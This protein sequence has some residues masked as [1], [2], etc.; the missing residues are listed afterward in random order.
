MAIG[1][2]LF[3]GGGFSNVFRV[4]PTRDPAAG[5]FLKTYWLERRKI[6]REKAA[7]VVPSSSL[8]LLSLLFDLR[9]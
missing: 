9:I 4:F 5:D 1:V 2:R 3:P 8:P 6:C 7:T